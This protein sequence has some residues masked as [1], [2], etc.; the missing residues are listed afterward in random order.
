MGRCVCPRVRVCVCVYNTSIKILKTPPFLSRTSPPPLPP[1]LIHAGRRK[2]ERKTETV[3]STVTLHLIPVSSPAFEAAI[4]P[5]PGIRVVVL[6]PVEVE[7][8]VS[9][10]V[11]IGLNGQME[12]NRKEE[13]FCSIGRERKFFFSPRERGFSFLFKPAEEKTAVFRF[14]RSVKQW[15]VKSREDDSRMR[16]GKVFFF[17]HL[18]WNFP[19]KIFFFSFLSFFPP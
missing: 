18:N 5:R 1:P 15:R 13:S 7:K 2:K 4:S 14:T 10:G 8:A 12:R 19:S 6:P 11:T 16:G 17:L 9:K 3:E